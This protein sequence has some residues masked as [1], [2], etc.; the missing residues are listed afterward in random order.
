MNT[1]KNLRE[2]LRIFN[3]KIF[4]FERCTVE[5]LLSEIENL[6]QSK[7]H[8]VRSLQHAAIKLTNT[9]KLLDESQGHVINMRNEVE[10]L[11][12][13]IR[14]FQKTHNTMTPTETFINPVDGKECGGHALLAQIRTL[15]EQKNGL[16]F[17]NHELHSKLVESGPR[18]FTSPVCG[19]LVN[20]NAL[21]A[22]AS[23]LIEQINELHFENEK[24]NEKIKNLQLNHGTDKGK[25]RQIQ[26]ILD[27]AE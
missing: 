13:A 25:L 27:K 26:S 10:S 19:S 17:E 21:L 20:A 18:L 23:K 2:M 22:Q 15:V 6:E 1:I 4:K 16:Y 7:N 14:V 12:G 11:H 8:F 9:E 3:P 24:L 5:A